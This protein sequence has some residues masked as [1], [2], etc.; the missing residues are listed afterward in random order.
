MCRPRASFP[1]SLSLLYLLELYLKKQYQVEVVGLANPVVCPDPTHTHVHTHSAPGRLLFFVL[2]SSH[3]C[4]DRRTEKTEILLLATSS[5]TETSPP[6]LPYSLTLPLSPRFFWSDCDRETSGRSSSFLCW[7]FCREIRP[8]D[9]LSP[10]S[11]KELNKHRPLP[12]VPMNFLSRRQETR[13]GATGSKLPV[14]AESESA[15]RGWTHYLFPW[16]PRRPQGHPLSA[17]WPSLS[18]G[19]EGGKGKRKRKEQ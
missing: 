3:I 17:L 12:V 18:G 15:F 2:A 11:L 13:A 6:S 9:N 14:C 10:S 19:R 7:C 5:H 8:S 1:M 4:S 16:E